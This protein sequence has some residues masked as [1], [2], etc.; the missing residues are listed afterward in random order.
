M[1]KKVALECSE[2]G[3]RNYSVPARPNHEER[4]ELKKFC[5]HCERVTVHRETR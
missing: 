3:R 1:V 2:C 5:K 4:L